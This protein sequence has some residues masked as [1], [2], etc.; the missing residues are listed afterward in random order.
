MRECQSVVECGIV[1]YNAEMLKEGESRQGEGR[2]R[3]H[4]FHIR[5]ACQ[6]VRHL[7]YHLRIDF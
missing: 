5:G 7:L 1:V 6:P 4:Y 3:L 2:L